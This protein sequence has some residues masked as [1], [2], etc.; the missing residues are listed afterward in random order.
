MKVT[1]TRQLSEKEGREVREIIER[2]K[3]ADQ[4][5]TEA[6]KQQLLGEICRIING[7]LS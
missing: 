6:E 7:Y 4:I 3:F 2:A 1:S 5:L